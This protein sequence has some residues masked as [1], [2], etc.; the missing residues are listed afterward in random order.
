MVARPFRRGE[1]PEDPGAARP[2]AAS[3]AA[4]CSAGET[5]APQHQPPQ[6]GGEFPPHPGA[7]AVKE[8]AGPRPRGDPRPGLRLGVGCGETRAARGSRACQ[9]FRPRP[10]PPSPRASSRGDPLGAGG[11]RGLSPLRRAGPAGAS[12]L[13]RRLQALQ[14]GPRAAARG[15][16]DRGVRARVALCWGAA[17]RLC[18][19]EA[20]WGLEPTVCLRTVHPHL[21]ARRG[22]EGGGQFRG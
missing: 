3:S 5:A 10:R 4:G 18:S 15:Q 11:F 2:Q 8:R 13:Q 1:G 17:C 9:H 21:D 7:R 6:P 16:W 22:G 12:E 19:W 20:S 14:P